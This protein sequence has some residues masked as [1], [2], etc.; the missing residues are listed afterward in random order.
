MRVKNKAKGLSL[1]EIILSIAVLAILSVYVI[2]MFITSSNLNH[3]AE[4]LDQSVLISESIFESI[5]LDPTLTQLH[6][7]AAFKYVKESVTDDADVLEIYFDMDWQPMKSIQEEGY[8][9]YLKEVRV[10][11]L[12]YEKADYQITVLTL[13]QSETEMLYEIG[14]Q[15]YY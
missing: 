6:Q 7:S 11:A 2:Q 3:K 14:M 5:E 15:K 13:D 10:Q 8:V 1:V 12:E 9:L 4:A